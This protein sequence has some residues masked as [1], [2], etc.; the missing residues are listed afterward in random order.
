M[1]HEMVFWQPSCEEL[2]PWSTV[3]NR[4][5]WEVYNNFVISNESEIV[6]NMICHCDNRQFVAG[7]RRHPGGCFKNTIIQVRYENPYVPSLLLLVE[8]I[9]KNRVQVVKIRESKV[10]TNAAMRKLK[11][12]QQS[13]VNINTFFRMTV[14]IIVICRF[15]MTHHINVPCCI[16][17]EPTQFK[18]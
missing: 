4:M 16:W 11:I 13:L 18:I 8:T 3:Y 9:A 14:I 15:K 12:L 5:K 10:L 17:S 2:T 7:I 6:Y 1:I